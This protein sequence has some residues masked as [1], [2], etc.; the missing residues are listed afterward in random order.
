MTE[1]EMRLRAHDAMSAAVNGLRRGVECD[2]TEYCYEDRPDVYGIRIEGKD[3]RAVAWIFASLSD[4]AAQ[5]PALVERAFRKTGGL[6]IDRPRYFRCVAPNG[7]NEL[8]PGVDVPTL[9]TV[10]TSILP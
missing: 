7:V 4:L 2:T 10:R 5:D 6:D 9:P 3:V 8:S 1:K